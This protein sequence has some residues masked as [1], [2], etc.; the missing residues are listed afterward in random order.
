MTVTNNEDDWRHLQRYG[1]APGNYMGACRTCGT[2][3]IDLDK[4][5]SCCR[6]CAESKHAEDDGLY[7]RSFKVGRLTYSYRAALQSNTEDAEFCKWL[8]AAE[9]GDVFAAGEGCTRID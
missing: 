4:R 6:P 7:N 9:V 3:C 8:E 2:T 5:A 1:Y